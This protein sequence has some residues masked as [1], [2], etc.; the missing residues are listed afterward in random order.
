[1]KWITIKN[2]YKS[3]KWK[4]LLFLFPKRTRKRI[5]AIVNEYVNDLNNILMQGSMSEDNDRREE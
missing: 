3:I 4:I 1:M 2:K 5:D